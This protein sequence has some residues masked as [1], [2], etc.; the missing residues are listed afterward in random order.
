MLLSVHNRT[1]NLVTVK[2]FSGVVVWSRRRY[3][4]TA[5]SEMPSR[6]ER[7]TSE[8]GSLPLT[9]IDEVGLPGKHLYRSSDT[10]TR[11]CP[12]QLHVVLNEGLERFNMICK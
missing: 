6:Q 7:L 4:C 8:A 12:S 3:S 9:M 11:G 10:D 5:G 2:A 1:L